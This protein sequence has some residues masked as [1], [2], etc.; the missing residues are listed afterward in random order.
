VKRDRSLR[1]PHNGHLT[2]LART[3]VPGFA[4]WIVFLL[5]HGFALLQGARASQLAGDSLRSRLLLWALAYWLAATINGAFDVYLE[6]PQG[7]IWFWSI[8]GIGLGT[9]AIP[10]QDRG[11]SSAKPLQAHAIR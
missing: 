1:S 10:P 2:I 7:G 3:G 8:V 5:A 6:G 9:L 4:L 11:Y